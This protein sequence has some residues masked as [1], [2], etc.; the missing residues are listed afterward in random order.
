[1]CGCEGIV[2]VDVGVAGEGSGKGLVVGL[3]TGS[4]AQVLQHGYAAV[5]QVGHD[6]LGAVATGSSVSTTS[7]SRSSTRQAATGMRENAG[8]GFP[9]GRAR[10][11]AKTTRPRGRWR[12]GWWEGSRECARHRRHRRQGSEDIEVHRMK[13][14]RP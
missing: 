11:E 10:C 1:M 6:L 12:A 4:E 2:D 14:R 13:T 3:F 7:R 8:F 9:L 5:A